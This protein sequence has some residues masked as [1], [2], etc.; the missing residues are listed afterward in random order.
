MKAT[1]NRNSSLTILF[2]CA[3]MLNV[4]LEAAALVRTGKFWEQAYWTAG[5]V[6]FTSAAFCLT[7]IVL[8]KRAL[9][10]GV[11]NTNL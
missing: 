4:M 5:E 10:D 1:A 6:V 11:Q 2:I 9:R 7:A 3:L 8:H